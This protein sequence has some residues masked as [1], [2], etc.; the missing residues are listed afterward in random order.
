MTQS[1]NILT[2]R[3]KDA[4]VTNE[5]IFYR[6]KQCYHSNKVIFNFI[7]SITVNF[8]QEG[9]DE[10]GKF[11]LSAKSGIFS[12]NSNLSSLTSGDRFDFLVQSSNL[13]NFD[14][15]MV[16]TA[17]IKVICNYILSVKY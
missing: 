1:E 9:K 17:T 4:D 6:I 12:L 14:D 10:C 15:E 16:D 8:F 13:V 7:N 2:V 5:L 11:N 3:S